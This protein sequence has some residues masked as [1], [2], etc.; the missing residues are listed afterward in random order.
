M[1]PQAGGGLEGARLCSVLRAVA[2]CRQRVRCLQAVR[3]ALAPLLVSLAST[4]FISHP[5][6]VR[7]LCLLPRRADTVMRLFEVVQCT[8]VTFPR[9]I[10]ASEGL[11]ALL[12]GML[13]KVRGERLA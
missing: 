3:A 8:P 11:K 2:A 13:E 4:G 10:P 12:L 6:P 1:R 9:D 7:T 5:P